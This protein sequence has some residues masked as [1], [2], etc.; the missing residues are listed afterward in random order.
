MVQNEVVIDEELCHGCGY[1]VQFCPRGCL[2]IPGEQPGPM[3]SGYEIAKFINPEQ[4]NACGI[5]TRMC[6]CGAIEVYLSIKDPRKAITREKVAGIP[7][8]L[9]SVGFGDCVGCQKATVG[10]II[11][12]VLDEL[13]LEGKFMG[14]DAVRCNSSS[15]FGRD[16]H[17][18]IEREDKPVSLH[19]V[20]TN[21]I[22][23]IDVYDNP[24]S[25]AL[26]LKRTH[27]ANVVFVVQDT[28]KFDAIGID[29]FDNGL[30]RG[31]NI[32]VI[33]CNELIYR[34]D[35]SKEQIAPPAS[36][37]NSPE[38]RNLIM[39]KYPL[40]LAERAATFSG[41]NYSARGAITSPDDY[42]R[43][44]SYIRTAFQKQTTNAGTSFVEVL[45]ACFAQA[46]ESPWDTLKWIHE[47]VVTELPLLEF[48]NVD[49][50]KQANESTP[51]G[52]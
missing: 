46:Y 24:I 23:T 2:D 38:R 19:G 26:E 50:M 14:L 20:R 13:G 7:R 6:P 21:G 44:K 11:A 27:P 37:V 10:R 9:S 1:C 5:C 18:T 40:H 41:I 39:G 48:K 12:D 31:E 35:P 28:T 49:Q 52:V 45:C 17:I 36:P 16:F 42:E 8:L 3:Y 29:S 30:M 4:C 43:T 22:S 51:S 15:A 32:T 34:G 25:I 47:K 33:N